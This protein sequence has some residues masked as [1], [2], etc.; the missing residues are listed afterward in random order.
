MNATDST[1]T[2]ILFPRYDES[3]N[4]IASHR[5]H[6]NNILHIYHGNEAAYKDD[7]YATTDPTS[8][9]TSIY[10]TKKSVVEVIKDVI[11]HHHQSQSNADCSNINRS[12]SRSPP[13]TIIVPDG[14]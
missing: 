14:P 1:S 13:L 11:T 10:N 3:N 8:I 2:C 7:S 4:Q 12:V 5:T 6:N 9:P